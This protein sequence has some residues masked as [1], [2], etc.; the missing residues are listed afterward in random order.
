MILKK[1]TFFMFLPY[2]NNL[3]ECFIISVCFFCFY[4]I[5]WYLWEKKNRN[6]FVA[7]FSTI[8]PFTMFFALPSLMVYHF[9]WFTISDGL[10]SLMVYHLWWVTISDGLRSLM[11]YHLWWVTI[12]DGL[13]SLMVYHLWWLAGKSYNSNLWTLIY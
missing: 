3:K 13:P 6:R 8:T 1:E 4:F 11:V 10:S 9:W 2:V 12:Y 7:L 5:S